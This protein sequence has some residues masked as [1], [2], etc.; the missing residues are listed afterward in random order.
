MLWRHSRLRST[1][2]TGAADW[3]ATLTMDEEQ[4]TAVNAELAAFNAAIDATTEEEVDIVCDEFEEA[5]NAILTS[6]A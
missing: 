5:V 1:A 6:A 3:V 4:T 2:K